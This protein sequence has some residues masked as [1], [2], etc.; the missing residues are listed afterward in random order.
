VEVVLTVRSRIKMN[1]RL[2]KKSSPQTLKRIRAFFTYKNPTFIANE[3]FGYSNHETQEFY[4]AWKKKGDNYYFGRGCLNR[5]QT[6][7]KDAGHSVLI[8]NRMHSLPPVDWNSKTILR[9]EQEGAVQAILKGESG[10]CKGDCSIGKTVILL[11]AMARSGQPAIIS[12]WSDVHQKQWI[13]EALN[14]KLTNLSPDQIGG[15]GG[16]FNSKKE[17]V[18]LFG[19][20]KYNKRPLGILNVCMQQSLRNPEHYKFFQLECGFIGFDEC[21]DPY[22][23]ITTQWG[24]KLLKDLKEGEV[25][26][27]PDDG[28]AKI[29]KI[30]KKKTQ[31]YKYIFENGTELI[32]SENHLM[33]TQV[34]NQKRLKPSIA[35]REIRAIGESKVV[36]VYNSKKMKGRKRNYRN[37]L[38]GWFLADGCIDRKEVKFSFSKKEKISEF[39]YILKKVPFFFK[40][41]TNTRGDTI[42][43]SKDY[44]IYLNLNWGIE[45]KKSGTCRIPRKLFFDCDLD[46]VQG[47]IDCDGTFSY[48]G[49]VEYYSTSK[50]LANQVHQILC[51]QGIPS[52]MWS[53]KKMQKNQEICHRVIVSGKSIETFK[54]LIGFSVKSKAENLERWLK[55]IRKTHLYF[56]IKKVTPLGER[57]LIDIELDNEEKLFIANGLIS[58]NCQYYGALTFDAM[59]HQFPALYRVGVTADERRK[60]KKQFLIYDSIGSVIHQVETPKKSSSRILAKINLVKSN[61]KDDEYAFDRDYTELLSRMACDLERNKLIILRAKKKLEQNKIVLILVERKEQALILQDMLVGYK[62]ELLIGKQNNKR[63]IR[64][65]ELDDGHK[66]LLLNYDADESFTRI[67]DL[68]YRKKLD[69]IIATKKGDVGLN[70]KTIEHLVIGNPTGGDINRFNQQKG[71]VERTYFGDEWLLKTFGEKERP[72]VDYIWDHRMP[73]FYPHRKNIIDTFGKT[74]RVIEDKKRKKYFKGE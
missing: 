13:N 45:E 40:K 59:I 63:A 47:L 70:S 73:K 20:R 35:R 25:I 64:E 39:E 60:D 11:E 2:L 28:V 15:V 67:K 55:K 9:A 48:T 62:G 43:R 29:K 32:A 30:W 19:D 6:I 58:H 49:Q 5:L 65:S 17:Y 41:A 54:R 38:L 56:R 57:E 31:A 50:I 69:Y 21:L 61:Y 18:K 23:L 46:V 7:L 44:L 72:T 71:R 34:C 36:E 16:I 4:K 27:T 33:A 24:H 68:A 3:N 26:R 1:F 52:R 37:I 12:V 14:S 42:F 8:R 51:S 53:P 10:L 66:D 74:V 22:T